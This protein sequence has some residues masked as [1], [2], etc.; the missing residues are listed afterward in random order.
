MQSIQKRHKTVGNIA[1]WQTIKRKTIY[2]MNIIK[3]VE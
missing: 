2:D 3:Q 1:R